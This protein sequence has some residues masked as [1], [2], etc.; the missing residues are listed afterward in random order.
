MLYATLAS[1]QLGS[2][3]TAAGAAVATMVT[4]CSGG[5]AWLCLIINSGRRN[6][7]DELSRFVNVGLGIGF[8]L[9]IPSA[10][11]VFLVN[12]H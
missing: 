7:Y 3:L 12:L 6:F 11:I 4:V 5:L 2:R 8:G 1:T 10:V 9:S